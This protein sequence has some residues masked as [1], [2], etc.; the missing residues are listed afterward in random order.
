MKPTTFT[1]LGSL[2]VTSPPFSFL[3]SRE[4]CPKWKQRLPQ[5][6]KGGEVTLRLPNGLNVVGFIRGNHGL[7]IGSEAYIQ[8]PEQ[9]VVIALLG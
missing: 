2:K 5:K 9:S 6:E 3:G 7:Q 1:P 8:I 4:T